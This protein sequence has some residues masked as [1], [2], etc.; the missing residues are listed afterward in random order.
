M[1]RRSHCFFPRN[2][3]VPAE[4]IAFFILVFTRKE[5]IR[6]VNDG[7]FIANYTFWPSILY[8]THTIPVISTDVYVHWSSDSISCLVKMGQENKIKT[9]S[10]ALGP[11]L[12]SEQNKN[13]IYFTR[14]L[15]VFFCFIHVNNFLLRQSMLSNMFTLFQSHIIIAYDLFCSKS[16]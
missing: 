14:A 12:V 11:F 2:T 7:Q 1:N 15:F 3:I 5:Q 4:T 6:P 16:S 13:A 8:S 9:N 10:P